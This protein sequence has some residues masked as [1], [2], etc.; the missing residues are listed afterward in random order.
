M[1]RPVALDL[2]GC[3]GGMAMA[4]LLGGF[5]VAAT[6][7]VAPRWAS[8]IAMNFQ[9][10]ERL[11]PRAPEVL[12]VTKDLLTTRPAILLKGLGVKPEL[13]RWVHGSPPCNDHSRDGYRSRTGPGHDALRVLG[14]W[15]RR[16]PGAHITLENVHG[17]R[18]SEQFGK[19]INDLIRQGREL[20]IYEVN[21]TWYGAPQ[22]RERVWLV[23]GPVGGR[24]IPVPA[25][26]CAIARPRTWSWA[27]K[28]PCP[29]EEIDDNRFT[30]PT[31]WQLDLLPHVPEGGTP[32]DATDPDTRRW[33][34]LRYPRSQRFIRRLHRDRP[35]PTVL[36]GV[37]IK[38]KL[39][40]VHPWLNRPGTVREM[41]RFQG[42]PDEFILPPNLLEAYRMIGEAVPIPMGLAFA[43]VVM[44]ALKQGRGRKRRC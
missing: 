36:T 7:D 30:P 11:F 34:D 17:V 20:A 27:M 8:I 24:C 5:A 18:S 31:S 35:V 22:N 38:N 21:A 9:G 43:R 33:L 3:G 28:Y 6:V 2:F 41:A 42:F 10:T 39:V 37:L 19:T 40:H 29:I 13:I 23:A 1:K 26:T 14:G 44:R 12:A 15:G 16:C 4:M 32:A 25:P